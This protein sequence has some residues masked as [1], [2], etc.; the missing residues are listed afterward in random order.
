[1][2]NRQARDPGELRDFNAT[3]RISGDVASFAADTGEGWRALSDVAGQLSGR[4]MQLYGEARVREDAQG[5]LAYVQNLSNA[6]SYLA[7][8]AV[9]RRA[10]TRAEAQAVT[11]PGELRQIIAEAA[12]RNGVSEKALLITANLESRFNPNAKNPN[13]S[14]GGLFQQIDSNARQYGV[15]NRF[16]PRQS[17]EGA[18]RFMA[19]NARYLR[20]RLGREPTPAEL[21]LAHQQGPGGA[22]KLLTNPNAPA[23]SIVG[24]AAVRLNGGKPGMTAGEF[25]SIW[26]KKAGGE[27]SAPP[28]SGGGGT[29][30]S[31]SYGL[32]DL[33]GAPLQLRNDGTMAGEAFDRA[34]TAAYAWRVEQGLSTDIANASEQFGDDP[35]GFA[36]RMGEIRAHYLQDGSFNDPRLREA[37]DRRFSS[38]AEAYSRSVAANHERKLKAAEGAAATEAIDARR[39]SVE[40]QAFLLGANP[41]GDRLLTAELDRAGRQIDA[42]VESGAMTPAEAGTA[43]R[44]LQAGAA[45]GRIQGVFDALATPAEKQAFALSILDDWAKGE[46]PIAALEYTQ[47]KAISDTLFAQARSLATQETA[48]S[49]L[50]KARV[51]EAIRDDVASM[52]AT[53]QGLPDLAPAAVEAALGPEGLEAWTQDRDTARKAWQATTG[54]EAESADDI[55]ARL[56]TLEPKP[57][58]PGYADDEKIFAAAERR[59]KQVLDERA[60]DPAKAVEKAFP[61]VAEMAETANPAEPDAMRAL[62]KARLQ[63]Q[64]ALDIEELGRAPLTNAEALSLARAVTQTPDPGAQ[65]KAMQQLV[66]QVQTVYGEHADAVLSQVLRARGMDRDMAAY[67]AQLFSRMQR[68]GAPGAADARRGQVASENAAANGAMTPK[69][70]DAFPIPNYRQ[71]QML[72]QNPELAQ[73]YDAKF[74]PGAAARLLGNRPADPSRRKVDGGTVIREPGGTEGFIPDGR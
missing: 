68:A 23:A 73:Q 63:A 67:G 70:A 61:Q 34:A 27:V 74:G 59:A 39:L 19:D 51:K 33:N 2:A 57:G 62:V 71:Q 26:L 37:F 56:A 12:R 17:A 30:A 13:S 58:T 49:K 24:A 35:A 8:R 31:V 48:V 22:A 1:M 9:E 7:A 46:G 54:M 15:A 52:A 65:A 5:G 43:R 69:A 38:E 40:K 44:E 53:G 41:E 28:S 11:A 47:A 21:Y 6:Q 10:A 3:A 25:A 55:A 64:E 18:A 60:K 36:K 4:L 42:A 32:P 16:D 66:E 72:L 50:E 14:A 20:G 29:P 45:R